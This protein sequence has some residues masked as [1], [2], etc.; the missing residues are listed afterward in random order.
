MSR[1]VFEMIFQPPEASRSSDKIHAPERYAPV[2]RLH[3]ENAAQ[4]Q[5]GQLLVSVAENDGVDP[6]DFS[7]DLIDHVFARVTGRGRWRLWIAV[8]PGMRGQDHDVGMFPLAHFADRSPRCVHAIFKVIT[9]IVFFRLPVG[10]RRRSDGDDGD[11]NARDGLDEIWGE[12]LHRG[13]SICDDIGRDPR[14]V[15]RRAGLGQVFQAEVELVIA[16]HHGVVADV[17][18]GQHHRVALERLS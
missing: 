4:P 17:I 18:H 11:F 8:E 13:A 5:L 6:F 14:E 2:L 16:H 3:Q 15:R 10:N 9:V 1:L 7:R 12:R